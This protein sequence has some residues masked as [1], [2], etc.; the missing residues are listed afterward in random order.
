M[1]KPAK[2]PFTLKTRQ[3]KDVFNGKTKSYD[4]QIGIYSF[5]GKL[6][7]LIVKCA[8]DNPIKNAV[9]NLIDSETDQSFEVIKNE[10]AKLESMQV[11]CEDFG[12]LPINLE[13][14]GVKTYTIQF[15][16]SRIYR[17]CMLINLLEMVTIQALNLETS[18]MIS[19][20]VRSDVI[21]TCQNKIR[22]VLYICFKKIDEVLKINEI[23][24]LLSV[25][26]DLFLSELNKHHSKE[27]LIET[28]GP[29]DDVKKPIREL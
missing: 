20:S 12:Y 24:S 21:Y 22:R 25:S 17:L 19:A 6:N 3:A 8:I 28:L 7:N 27:L 11:L 16:N 2:Y 29:L 13:F 23:D 4:F 15:S 5:A 1:I 14:S 10:K 18:S 9:L 26:A